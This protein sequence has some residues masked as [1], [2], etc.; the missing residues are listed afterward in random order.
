MSGRRRRAI[1]VRGE[2]A[3]EQRADAERV[4]ELRI[5]ALAPEDVGFAVARED[6]LAVF[7]QADRV[8]RAAVLP[9]VVGDAGRDP[10]DAGCLRIG[11][12]DQRREAD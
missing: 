4:E 2:H 7:V 1:V 6:E 11:D 8:H 3:A 10:A 9:P 12:G 5:D